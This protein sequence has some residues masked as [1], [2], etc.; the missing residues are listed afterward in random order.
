MI[1]S[2]IQTCLWVCV[3]LEECPLV[4]S[5]S[6]LCLSLFSLSRIEQSCRNLFSILFCSPLDLVFDLCLIKLMIITWTSHN[7][8]ISSSAFNYEMTK[9]TL[10]ILVYIVIILCQ[11]FMFFLKL[12]F[13]CN[14]CSYCI[15]FAPFLRFRQ[16][17]QICNILWLN[18][19]NNFQFK[20]MKFLLFIQFALHA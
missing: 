11:S 16:I 9:S 12:N 3:S 4:L 15:E 7:I 8:Y 13:E 2:H 20:I 6:K 1:F 10:S 19:L 14:Q 5:K 18:P 17:D